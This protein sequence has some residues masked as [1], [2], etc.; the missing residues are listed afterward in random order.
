[1]LQMTGKVTNVPIEDEDVLKSAGVLPRMEDEIGTVNVA[2]KRRRKGPYYRKAEL[3]RPKKIDEALRHLQ[4]KHP[5][6]FNFPIEYLNDK[7][8]YKFVNLPLIGYFEEDQ[9]NLKNLDAAYSFL[10]NSNLLTE[11]LSPLLVRSENNY[12]NFYNQLVVNKSPR[13]QDSFIHALF[14]QMR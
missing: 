13:D 14:D 8:K 2:F 4:K 6:Y 9:A 12:Q 1:M 10:E 3:I 11:L 7:K 5:S